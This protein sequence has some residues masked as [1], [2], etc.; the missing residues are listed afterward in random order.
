MLNRA[1]VLA[2]VVFSASAVAHATVLS[3]WNLIVRTNVSS[4][5]EVDGSTLIG[6][7]L[8]GTSNYTVQGVTNPTG[9]GL[10]V[11][12]NVSGGAISVN[13]GGN[14]RFNGTVSSIINLSG[15][16][17]APDPTIPAQVTSAFNQVA[18]ISSSLASLVAN[19]TLD[20]G[21]NMNAVPTNL[22]GQLVAV[23]NLTPSQWSS[24]GQLN[25]N[26][27]A[28][29]SVIINVLTPGNISFVAPPNLIGGFN[30]ANSGK[31][32]W[33]IPNATNVTV[34]NSFN[35]AILAPNADLKLLSGAINGTVV[36][37]SISQQSAEIRRSTYTGYIPAP[38]AMGLL[39]LAGLVAS[40]RRR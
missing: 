40:R 5:S 34:G 25:L 8:V 33:N 24:L 35:G 16:N 18:S 19:G 12:G 29:S 1:C 17:S 27:G 23:Y 37:N 6:G 22:G 15:G 10:A 39:G 3:D 32:L 26:F 20:G 11:G 28:A 7:N 21:G 14:F 4:S 9:V 36:V 31:I 30:Q 2:G 13:N 38:G